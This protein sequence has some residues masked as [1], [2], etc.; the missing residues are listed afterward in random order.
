MND[1]DIL[2]REILQG[3]FSTQRTTHHTVDF[4]APDEISLLQITHTGNLNDEIAIQEKMFAVICAQKHGKR[5]SPK[6]LTRSLNLLD[7]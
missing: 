6:M 4:A 3:R 2:S 7:F 1:G 5:R